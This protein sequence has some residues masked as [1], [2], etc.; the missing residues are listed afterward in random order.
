MKAKVD[1]DLCVGCGP[2]ED[3]CPN[4]FPVVDGKAI[5]KVEA[6]PPKDEADCKNAAESCPTDA[7]TI[8]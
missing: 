5:V 2:C 1:P 3:I 8:E 6:V 4:V 7:N